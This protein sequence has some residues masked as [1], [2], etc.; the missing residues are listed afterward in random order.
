MERKNMT[1]LIRRVIKIQ[2]YILVFM[3]KLNEAGP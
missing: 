2:I 3:S 1:M